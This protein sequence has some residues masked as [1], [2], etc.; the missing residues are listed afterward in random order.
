MFDYMLQVYPLESCEFPL[1]LMYRETTVS[2]AQAE[3]VTNTL[4]DL[5]SSL[6]ADPSQSVSSLCQLSRF[7]RLQLGAWNAAVP[8]GTA[9]TMDRLIKLSVLKSP[10][11]IALVSRHGEM[12]YAEFDQATCRVAKYL[13]QGG[14]RQ[15]QLVPICFEKSAWAIITMV[16]L[17]KL[18]AA[19]VPLDATHPLQRL[20]AVVS[21]VEADTAIVSPSNRALVQNIVRRAMVVDSTLLSGTEVAFESRSQA[22]DTAFVMF[23]SGSTGKPKGVVHAHSAVCSSALHHGPAMDISEATRAL[24]FAS[25]TFI[26]STFELFTPLL[27]GGSVC[28]PSDEDRR[29]D[30]GPALQALGANWAIFTP[31]FARSLS[32]DDTPLHTLIFAG[33]PVQDDILDRW[34]PKANIISIYGT[35]ECSVCMTGRMVHGQ[36]ARNCIGRATG[37]LSWIVD[38]ADHNRLVPIGA[39]G[40]LVIEGP[41]LGEGYLGEPHRT[42]AAYIEEARCSWARVLGPTSSQPRRFYKT[43]DLVRYH[44][45]G[46]VHLVGRADMQVKVCGQR[47]ELTEVEAHLCQ[48]SPSASLKFAVSLVSPAGTPPMLAAFVARKSGFDSSPESGYDFSHEPEP[49]VKAE[50]SELAMQMKT[51]LATMLPSYMIPAVFLPLTYMPLMASGKTDRRKLAAFGS[52]LSQVQLAHRARATT[53]SRDPS[54]GTPTTTDMELQ[55]LWAK[56]L[57]RG[58]VADVGAGDNFFHWGGD[59]IQAMNLSRA[60]RRH[61]FVLAVHHILAKP[62]LSDM[63]KHMTPMAGSGSET[64]ADADADTDTGAETKSPRPFALLRGNVGEETQARTAI[65]AALNLDSDAMEKLDDAYPCTPLQ[66]GLMALSAKLPGSVVDSHA[67]LRTRILEVHGFGIVQAILSHPIEWQIAQH[68]DSYLALDEQRPMGMGDALARHAIVHSNSHTAPSYY[69]LTIHHAIY[70]GLSLPILLQ[71]L[72]HALRGAAIGPRPQFNSFIRYILAS[73]REDAQQ[74]WKSELS[75]VGLASFPA[76]PLET[77]SPLANAHFCHRIDL[78]PKT[79]SDFTIATLLKAAWGLLQARYNDSPQAVFGCAVSGRISPVPGVQD[80]VGPVLATVPVKVDLDQQQSVQDF[81]RRIQDQYVAMIPFQD[82]GLQNIARL[83]SG[84][85]AACNFQTLLVIQPADSQLPEDALIKSF[86]APRAN[87]TTV[88]LSLE[89]SLSAE[90]IHL[91][92]HFD[93]AILTQPQV[94][95]MVHQFEHLVLQLNRDPQS[96]LSDLDLISPQ[97]MS[98]VLRWNE[99]IPHVAQHCVHHL[100]EKQNVRQPSAPAVCSWDGDLTYAQLHHSSSKLAAHLLDI[101]I[102]TEDI[103][104]ICFEKSMWA[105]VA[106]LGIM[107]AGGAFVALDPD[108]PYSRLFMVTREVGARV[109]VCSKEQLRRFPDLVDRTVTIGPCFDTFVTNTPIQVPLPVAVTPTGAAY[110]IFTSGSTGTPKG[111]V[112]EHQAFCTSA[113]AHKEGLQMKNRVLQFASYTFDVS[114]VEILSTLI[115]GGCVCVPSEEE[116]RGHIAE[117]IARMRTNWA[118]LTPSFLSTL[119]PNSVPSLEVL[120][121]AGETTSATLIEKWAPHVQLVNGYGPSECCVATSNRNVIIGSNPRNIGVAVGAACWVADLDNHHRLS[122]VGCVGELLIEGHTLARHYLNQAEKTAEAFIPRPAWLPWNRCDRLYRTGDLVQYMPDGSMLFLGR[123]D[124]QVKIRGQRVELGEIEHNLAMQDKVALAVVAY[125]KTGVYSN[126]LVAIIEPSTSIHYTGTGIQP[127]SHKVLGEIGFD[128]SVISQRVVQTLPTH[129]VPAIWIIVE[130]MPTL[131]ST[132]I[133]RSLVNTWL[134]NVPSDFQPAISSVPNVKPSLQEIPDTEEIAV[135]ISNKIAASMNRGDRTSFQRR[136]FNI[137]SVGIDSIEIISLVRFIEQSY[138]VKVSVAKIL[139]KHTTI[140][141]LA[142]LI[143]ENRD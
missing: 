96:R 42:Q 95:R 105:I 91:R 108:A 86:S 7:D 40:E 100:I 52:S 125:P 102:G 129:M 51:Q 2:Q 56:V 6:C 22:T 126:K 117:A 78:Q 127:L 39:V 45:D 26:V 58:L 41:S 143:I 124:T 74:F 10:Q 103:V 110:V 118:V 9:T 29:T 88:A 81:L 23:T 55:R 4:S 116:R 21:I 48:L 137:A 18:G 121:L 62:I 14:I 134:A 109:M 60:A 89:C 113:L 75:T 106:M 64:D 98:D 30:M 77:Y 25:Y 13:E 47:V 71:D 104:P 44:H 138:K 128:V 142:T 101:G 63:A 131:P 122:P 65:A 69:V 112:M 97:D 73:N 1:S 76:L 87:F 130:K 8:V 136:D 82:Y 27:F 59:S 68:V 67:A 35:S 43:G 114:I 120:C 33:E 85:S 80:M 93:N 17:W 3:R 132:K 111:F 54:T 12:T 79:S 72:N 92:C 70:D 28:I 90:S 32:S 123:K 19:Y 46:T 49:A 139:D 20:K 16:A 24:Q 5:L 140:R 15:G 107:K 84:A 53:G 99:S 141:S 94:Q 61:G 66:E 57:G 36:T 135:A 50:L 37:A 83:C 119:D 11:A 34:A 31:S 38:P 115:H 133:D